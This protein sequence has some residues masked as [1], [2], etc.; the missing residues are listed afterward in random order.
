MEWAKRRSDTIGTSPNQVVHHQV[1]L[2]EIIGPSSVQLPF[3]IAIQFGKSPN[4]IRQSKPGS[5]N[6]L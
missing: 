5:P 6:C 1:G 2:P 4:P 3:S